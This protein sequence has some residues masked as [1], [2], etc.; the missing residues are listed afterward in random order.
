MKRTERW[1]V[2]GGSSNSEEISGTSLG[3]CLWL[4]HCVS[5]GRPV[6]APL[7]RAGLPA[8]PMPGSDFPIDELVDEKGS[9]VA[10]SRLIS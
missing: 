7:A 9:A 5:D 10:V 4:L 3:L 1:S 6:R 2:L 8:R